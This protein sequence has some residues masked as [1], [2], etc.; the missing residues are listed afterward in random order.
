ME[1]IG[2]FVKNYLGRVVFRKLTGMGCGEDGNQSTG[3]KGKA[4]TGRGHGF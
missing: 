2:Y 3:R 1:V 4:V